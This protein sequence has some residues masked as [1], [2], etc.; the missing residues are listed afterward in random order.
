MTGFYLAVVYQGVQGQCSTWHY[1]VRS[2]DIAKIVQ[3][4]LGLYDTIET[5]HS[6]NV[7]HT[8]TWP[9]IDPLRYRV[10]F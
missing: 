4:V 9:Q 8:C 2:Y 10:L 6:W 7:S 1:F 5:R 3:L